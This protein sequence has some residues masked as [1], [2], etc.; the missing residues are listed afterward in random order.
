MYLVWEALSK[1]VPDLYI[2]V[3][4]FLLFCPPG[5]LREVS[6]ILLQIR[7]DML[8][9]F[10]SLRGLLASPLARM[11]TTPPLALIC[12]RVW[13]LARRRTPIQV[14]SRL[15]RFEAASNYSESIHV[16]RPQLEEVTLPRY[17]RL[18]MYYYA[19][20]LRR[21][22]FLLVNS[23]WT[24]NHVDSILAHSDPFLDLMH[25][26]LISIGSLFLS[27]TRALALS[28]PTHVHVPPK[29]AEIVYPPC[30]T[31]A[32]SQLPL[33]RRPSLLLSLAQFRSVQ[34][35][36][37]FGVVLS[38]FV[39]TRDK[40]GKGSCGADSHDGLPAHAL[41]RAQPVYASVARRRSAQRGR[42]QARRGAK[43]TRRLTPGLGMLPSVP[44]RVPC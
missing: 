22:S 31:H 32:L 4:R 2:G 20:A 30:D 35:I 6:V 13:R 5:L 24:K 44:D 7:W 28:S 17:Y 36:S 39:L 8:L 34:Y 12:L 42:F 19:L 16:P 37:I 10:M 23:S 14:Q 3:P 21:S 33:E 40:A 29:R 15:L 9:H 38:A 11:C 26:P 41:S 18:F 1:F 25:L 43:R 27:L